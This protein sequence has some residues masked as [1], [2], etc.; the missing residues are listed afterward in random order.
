MGSPF[1]AVLIAPNPDPGWTGFDAGFNTAQN[2]DHFGPLKMAHQISVSEDTS[3][4]WSQIPPSD[5][6][7]DNT[8]IQ[9]A[10]SNVTDYT[11]ALHV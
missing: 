11:S 7:P 4:P 3:D 6:T 1:D 2:G 9:H 5:S 10:G 8:Q